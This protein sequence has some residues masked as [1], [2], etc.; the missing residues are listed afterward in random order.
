MN[1]KAILFWAGTVY[2]WDYEAPANM[3]HNTAGTAANKGTV[4][5]KAGGF[6]R[7]IVH[8]YV[9]DFSH[10]E[11]LTSSWSDGRPGPVAFCVAEGKLRPADIQKW[12]AEHVGSSLIISS[13][14]PTHFMNAESLIVVLEQLYSPAFEAQRKRYLLLQMITALFSYMCVCVLCWFHLQACPQVLYCKTKAKV[15]PFSS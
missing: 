10:A 8:L 13:Q 1:W 2:P 4:W 11:V 14:T 12:N 3:E 9:Q 7:C 5:Q 6:S 15:Q